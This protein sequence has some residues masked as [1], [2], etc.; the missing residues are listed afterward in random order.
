M[1]GLGGFGTM[2]PGMGAAMSMMSS[3]G[4][5]PGMSGMGGMPD[6]GDQKMTQTVQDALSKAGKQV[7]DELKAGKVSA[8]GDKK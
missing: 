3:A 2:N 6:M 5:I 1:G 4:A 7:S 8:G